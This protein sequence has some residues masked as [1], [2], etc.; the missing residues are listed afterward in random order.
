MEGL[1]KNFRF[2]VGLDV[3]DVLLPCV[4]LAVEWANRDYHFEPPITMDE[5]KTWSK[6]G[7]RTDFN[8]LDFFEAQT[9]LEGAKEFVRKLSKRAE[10]FA[11]TAIKPIYMGIRSAQLT[12]FFPEI[13]EVNYIP[14]Y[15][16]DVVELDFLL[17][18]GAHNIL[19]SNVKYPVLFRRPWNANMTGTL[20]VNSYDEFLN[21]IDCIKESYMDNNISF[22]RPTVI[23]LIGPSGSGKSAIAAELLKNERFDKP[24]S[25]TT[26]KPRSGEAENTYHFV[27]D[28]EFTQMMHDQKFAETTVYAG[29][30]YGVEL[31]S[32]NNVLKNGKHCV[33]PIDVSGA[34]ALKMQYRTCLVYIKRN[35]L[36][37]IRTL[38]QRVMDGQSTPDDVSQRIV[39][40]DDE[41]QNECIC[42]FT[43]PND[44]TLDEAMQR[45]LHTMRIKN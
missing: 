27:T 2:R 34:M 1:N 44:G 21:L 15:R 24:V 33:I 18:D 43:L 42:D 29:K 19:A 45:L 25:A 13:P 17:D 3:D 16:K 35:R 6:S 40:L 10:V 36:S 41:K 22:S 9:P 30:R 32:I 28:E 14:A 20:A 8:R 11:V 23:A 39:A 7:T 5:V 38:I 26:R 12:K 37:I 31:A 4:E